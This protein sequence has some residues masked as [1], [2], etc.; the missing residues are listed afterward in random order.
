MF[1]NI[2][3]V[4]PRFTA[5]HFLVFDENDNYLC[6]GSNTQIVVISLMEHNFGK[7]YKREINVDIYE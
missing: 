4:N 2:E 6:V 7:V 3:K 1:K 5:G